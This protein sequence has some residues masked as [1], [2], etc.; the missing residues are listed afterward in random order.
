MPVYLIGIK[1]VYKKTV[2]VTANNPKEAFQKLFDFEDCI[3]ISDPEY[4]QD[5][6]VKKWYISEI[7]SKRTHILASEAYPFDDPTDMDE[8]YEENIKK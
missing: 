4:V 7:D 3:V 1:E 5:F 8:W 6:E 2:E